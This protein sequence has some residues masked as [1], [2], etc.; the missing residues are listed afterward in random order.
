MG[1]VRDDTRVEEA[2]L[3]SDRRREEIT[4]LALAEIYRLGAEKRR[5][6]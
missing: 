5:S 6:N 4:L 2:S 1:D 3:E